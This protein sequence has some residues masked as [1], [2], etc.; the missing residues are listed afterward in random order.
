MDTSTFQGMLFTKMSYATVS[1]TTSCDIMCTSNTDILFRVPN[2]GGLSV[3][4]NLPYQTNISL[5]GLADKKF[6]GATQ[7]EK[8]THSKNQEKRNAALRKE[9]RLFF[10]NMEKEKQAT[11][12]KRETAVVIIQRYFRGYSVR[13]PTSYIRRHP[14]D[15]ITNPHQITK[16]IHEDLC[17]LSELLGLKPITGLSLN[18]YGGK[19]SRRRMRIEH[20]SCLKIQTFL[21]IMLARNEVVKRRRIRENKRLNNAAKVIQRFFKWIIRQEQVGAVIVRKR[22]H[23]AI[24]IQTR[25]RIFMAKERAREMKKWYAARKRRYEACLVIILFVFWG[26]IRRRLRKR[27]EEMK[28]L[29]RQSTM[30]NIQS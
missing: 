23:A 29:K 7:V 2:K 13:R 20:A 9:K 6:Q 21:R 14:N 5:N 16:D 8:Y 4:V 3:A 1:R 15:W 10:A 11:T 30:R 28:R 24:L 19:K 18:G 27:A 17:N 26:M 22:T 12:K 25:W